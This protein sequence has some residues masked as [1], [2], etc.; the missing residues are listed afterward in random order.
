ML[1]PRDAR[2]TRM[3]CH[4]VLLRAQDE[5]AVRRAHA[6][7]VGTRHACPRNASQSR[8][9]SSVLFDWKMVRPHI[10][11]DARHT[12]GN[13]WYIWR[14]AIPEFIRDI[15]TFTNSLSA[16]LQRKNSDSAIVAL[17]AWWTEGV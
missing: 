5:R 10:Q 13:A 2:L 15:A 17:S 1:V 7:R 16:S 4:Y 9:G 14:S 11:C 12:R 3:A 8:R 6:R